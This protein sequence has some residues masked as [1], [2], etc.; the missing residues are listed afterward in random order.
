[1]NKRL[2]WEPAALMALVLGLGLWIA[3]G[4]G[5]KP[6]F[7]L[8]PDALT[9][10]LRLGDMRGVLEAAKNPGE[11]D[12]TFRALWR[13]QSSPPQPISR[14]QAEA[15]FGPEAVALTITPRTN[16]VFKLLNITS[17]T[18]LVWVGIGLIGQLAFSGRMVLQW[19]VSERK[20][21][22]IISESFWWF[23]LFGGITLFSHFV[24]R[25]D[26]IGILGQATGIVIYAR[27]IR[28]IYK[29]KRRTIRDSE[30]N[31]S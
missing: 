29:A 14:A 21:E 19:I 8:R 28:L 16:W 20:R 11:S 5:G 26:P 23:S 22:S 31:P 2:K 1:M 9:S 13:D 24:W 27:N 6:K 18:N 25:A 7:P 10:E 17:W 12:Y 30:G 4:P 3:V 15:A